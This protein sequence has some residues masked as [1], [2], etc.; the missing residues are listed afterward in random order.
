M[1]HTR[2]SQQV[3]LKQRSLSE[4]KHLSDLNK[5]SQYRKKIFFL[6]NFE[7]GKKIFF[8]ATLTN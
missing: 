1:F 5:W 4:N 7:L 3:I 2:R 8:D 6:A